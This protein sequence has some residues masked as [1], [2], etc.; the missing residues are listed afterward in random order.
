M[1]PSH[2]VKN[3]RRYRYYVT[4]SADLRPESPLAWRM[5]AHD[6]EAALVARLSDYFRDYREIAVLAGNGAS[7]AAIGVLVERAEHAVKHLAEPAKIRVIIAKLVRSI[8]MADD[9]LRIELDR[10]AL[11]RLLGA[12]LRLRGCRRG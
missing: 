9:E 12:L 3:G 8:G 11:A 1:T 5:P 6:V 2:A 4:H 10:P 7:A